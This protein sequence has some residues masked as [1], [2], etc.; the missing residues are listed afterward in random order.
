MHR[1]LRPIL[2]LHPDDAFRERVRRA[3]TEEQALWIF[4]E[5][6][7][8][9]RALRD[10]PPGTVA[11]VDPYA[12][13]REGLS[14]SLRDLMRDFPSATILAASRFDTA[15]Y[16]DLRTLGSWGVAELICIGKEDSRAAVARR[17][18]VMQ[19]RA[20]ERVLKHAIPRAIP[21]RVRTLVSA[22]ADT[23]AAG[24]HA[25]E[26][27]AS[28]GLTE[29]TLLRWCARAHLPPPRRLL[30]WLRVLLAC[31]FL[32]DPG[33]TL[34]SV[35]RACGYAADMPLRR[36][37]RNLTGLE[38]PELRKQGALE[39]AAQAFVTELQ[40]L[41]G[42]IEDPLSDEVL[43]RRAARRAALRRSGVAHADAADVEMPYH[44]REPVGAEA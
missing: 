17:I 5:W 34:S 27:A 39:T 8:L 31:D 29:R 22:A 43:A 40:T 13:A 21:S 33:H 42:R 20:V 44:D 12:G 11:V 18:R 35:S 19:G 37:I 10:A 24:G 28:L 25:P 30:A 1:L 7:A 41:R 14:L 32:D 36:A 16:A 4:T 3:L 2:L 38:P 23:A 15:Q 6:G 9:R 26:L